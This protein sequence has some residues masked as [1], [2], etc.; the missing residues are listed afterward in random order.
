MTPQGWK[1][2]NTG[3]GLPHN[4]VWTIAVDKRYNDVWVG[5]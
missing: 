5:S 1:T 3:N 4:R 2:Y